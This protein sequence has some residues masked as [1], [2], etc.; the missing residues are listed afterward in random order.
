MT[1]EPPAA[2]SPD[3]RD[4][5]PAVDA[6]AAEQGT[7]ALV[8]EAAVLEAAGIT[9]AAEV[10][11]EAVLASRRQP[12]PTAPA[13]ADEVR[14]AWGQPPPG[15]ATPPPGE[16]PWAADLLDDLEP[17]A[18]PAEDLDGIILAEE[19]ALEE[20]RLEA[21]QLEL[22]RLERARLMG[23]EEE[24]AGHAQREGEREKALARF[25][26]QREEAQALLALQ[27]ERAARA[28]EV[29]ADQALEHGEPGGTTELEPWAHLDDEAQLPTPTLEP[30]VPDEAVADL[31]EEPAWGLSVE[32]RSEPD[33]EPER[34]FEPELDTEPEWGF[35]PQPRLEPELT[36]APFASD[37]DRDAEVERPG[38][39]DDTRRPLMAV[40]L[41]SGLGDRGPV[42]PLDEDEAKAEP[43]SAWPTTPTEAW[44]ADDADGAEDADIE[45]GAESLAVTDEGAEQQPEPQ[46]DDGFQSELDDEDEL[47]RQLTKDEADDTPLVA[48]S[49]LSSSGRRPI[50]ASDLDDFV[51]PQVV[52]DEEPA[53]ANVRRQRSSGQP[54]VPL[55][56]QRLAEAEARTGPVEVA[57]IQPPPAPPAPPAKKVTKKVTKRAEPASAPARA[58]KRAPSPPAATPKKVAKAVSVTKKAPTTPAKR[59][60]AA[61]QPATKKVSSRGKKPDVRW[62]EPVGGACPAS[63]PVKA[64]LSSGIFH[65]VGGLFYERSRA[66]RCYRDAAAATADGLRQAK[67]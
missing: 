44:P 40:D 49:P 26:A 13:A 47:D 7:A 36:A 66:D 6:A 31:D 25:A 21:E 64:S 58:G 62:V 35:Q 2:L 27:E 18:A 4:T 60:A 59:P 1:T 57:P 55:K 42:Q 16:A 8:A 28:A 33:L 45:A 53:P 48:G 38:L 43:L 23:E 52:D 34:Y 9:E 11:E 3:R 17:G 63:H 24:A 39:E 51:P 37:P 15:G 67:R 41:E 5:P 12:E 32:P 30:L 14:S 29:G 20:E 50:M 46:P 56:A 61:S 10:D 54:R 65:V 19:A 22:A